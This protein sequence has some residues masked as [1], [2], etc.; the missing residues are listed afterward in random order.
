MFLSRNDLQT[1]TGYRQPG[2]VCKWL[3]THG[4]RYLPSLSG[5]PVVAQAEAER[6]L[7]G[8]SRRTSPALEAVR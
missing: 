7:V 1:L 6:H 8:G 4:W 2:R 3:D 5:W